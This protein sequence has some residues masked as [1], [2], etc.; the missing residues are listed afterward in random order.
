MLGLLRGAG[1]K[2][3]GAVSG[4]CAHGY[5]YGLLQHGLIREFLVFYYA[6]MAHMYTRGTWT[7][8]ECRNTDPSKPSAPFCAPA[9][10]TIPILTKWMLVF[11]DPFSPTLWLGKSIPRSWLRDGKTVAV[12]GAP[13]RFGTLSYEISSKVHR[14]RINIE[15]HLPEEGA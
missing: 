6:Y 9:Q 15:L 8:T 7:V 2:L 12:K 1:K 4:L 11:E 5:A 3:D 14:G 13:T 10:L